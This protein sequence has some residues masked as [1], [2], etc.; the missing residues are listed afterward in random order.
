[1]HACTHVDSDDRTCHPIPNPNPSFR[2]ALPSP[3]P[4]PSPTPSPLVHVERGDEVPNGRAAVTLLAL[5]A[6]EGVAKPRTVTTGGQSRPRVPLRVRAP[7][8]LFDG[9]RLGVLEVLADGAA[10]GSHI[11]VNLPRH[12]ALVRA[13]ARDDDHWHVQLLAATV[14][15]GGGV[16]VE[17]VVVRRVGLEQRAGFGLIEGLHATL[18]DH[19]FDLAHEKRLLALQKPR[20]VL[21]AR[22]DHN[23]QAAVVGRREHLGHQLLAVQAAPV[24]GS[25]EMR[26]KGEDTR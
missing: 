2:P 3:S 8:E 26:S 9:C 14:E 19:L 1:M 6:T 17:L 4:S 18:D 5:A 11:V 7:P 16:V 12:L 24:E 20:H 15:E 22:H 23:G 25:V 10:C 13:E 21:E